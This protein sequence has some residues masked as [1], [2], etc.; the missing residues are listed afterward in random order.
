MLQYHNIVPVVLFGVQIHMTAVWIW[1]EAVLGVFISDAMDISSLLIL[2][3]S[4]GPSLL[5]VLLQVCKRFPWK[6][7]VW[8][9]LSCSVAHLLKCTRHLPMPQTVQVFA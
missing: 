2:L 6:A 4:K 1:L 3:Q 5:F 9:Y 7:S 8:C